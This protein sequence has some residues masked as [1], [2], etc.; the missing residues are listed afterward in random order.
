MTPEEKTRLDLRAR[1]AGV[2]T[3]EFVRRR[4]GTDAIEDYRDEIEALLSALEASAPTILRSLDSAI[5]NATAINATTARKSK[6]DREFRRE[7]SIR[8]SNNCSD[9]GAHQDIG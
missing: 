7:S 3:A 6:Q 2:S 1:R 8:P 5:E 4:V 9:R